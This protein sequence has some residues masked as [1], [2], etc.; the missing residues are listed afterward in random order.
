MEQ[1][2]LTEDTDK[3]LMAAHCRGDSDAFAA[4]VQRYGPALLGYLKKMSNEN[5]QAEDFFQETFARV[6]QKAH[7]F[8]GPKLKPW[9]YRIATNIAM[10]GF[11]KNSR[12]KFVSL[13]QQASGDDANPQELGERVLVDNA[14]SPSEAAQTAETKEQ[15]Q[16]A[17]AD[18]P[19]RQRAT[20][21]LAY[22]QRLSYRQVA[23]VLGCSVGT[24]K[25][26]MFRALKS[27]A[28]TLP[29][30]SGGAA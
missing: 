12:L 13:N 3:N 5:G 21:V 17:I 25:T 14:P 23:E 8:R 6:H 28:R 27:L 29:D 10:D 4:I 7:T 18:L 16:R 30:I 11:R 24:V 20:L 26:H 1:I 15:V 2:A 22:Y 19:D 9:L